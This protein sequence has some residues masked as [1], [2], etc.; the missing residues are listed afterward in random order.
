MH[1]NISIY[2]GNYEKEITITMCT[3]QTT[4]HRAETANYKARD[5]CVDYSSC[6]CIFHMK[7]VHDNESIP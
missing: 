2:G 5:I 3:I 7:I 4:E 6:V 1:I